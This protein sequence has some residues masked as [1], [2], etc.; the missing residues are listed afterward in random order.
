MFSKNELLPRQL[1][2]SPHRHIIKIAK[3]SWLESSYCSQKTEPPR[4]G[5]SEG[6]L[7][8]LLALAVTVKPLADVVRDYI[9]SDSY[10]EAVE[11]RTH[12]AHLLP[13]ARVEKGSEISITQ[14][15]GRSK[16]CREWSE[17]RKLNFL[18]L[19]LDKNCKRDYYTKQTDN[20][21]W[22][23]FT[24]GF[25]L[26]NVLGNASL[27]ADRGGPQRRKLGCGLRQNGVCRAAKEKKE[28]VS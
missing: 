8:G 5:H 11:Q 10:E 15:E 24:L 12:V 9:C 3:G 19:P 1:D 18:H 14:D 21:A 26:W 4:R 22:G 16:L 28:K 6:V 2:F 23:V 27:R 7:L 13:V 20:G 25:F 17:N